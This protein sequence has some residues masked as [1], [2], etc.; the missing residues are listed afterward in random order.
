MREEAK[1]ASVPAWPPPTTTTSSSCGSC[2]GKGQS[3]RAQIYR[4]LHWLARLC[5][6]HVERVLAP[7]FHVEQRQLF[8][9]AEFEEDFTEQIIGSELARDL[10]QRKLSKAKVFRSQVYLIHGMLGTLQMRGGS[11]QGVEVPFA[12]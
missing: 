4:N 1:A 3:E 12:R 6:F 2:M 7:M 11:R 10:R 9:E 8:A 5:M